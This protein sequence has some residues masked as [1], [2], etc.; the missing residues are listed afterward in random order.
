MTETELHV[1]SLSV[2][3]T[4]SHG[5][6]VALTDV[7]FKVSPGEVVGL[8]GE[9]GAGK[10][11]IARAIA[12]QLPNNADISGSIFMDGIDLLASRT[13]HTDL[14]NKVNAALCF[15]NPRLA[16]SP[17]RTIG[18]QIADRLGKHQN[19]SNR[20]MSDD[21][22]ELLRRVGIRDP[23]RM[24]KSFP[25]EL[26]GGMCQRAMIA[27]ALAC[28]S[29]VLLADEPTTGLDVTL[30]R[31]ILDLF[32][33]MADRDHRQVLVISHD[34][35]AIASICDRLLVLYAG[36]LVEAGSTL[37]IVQNPMHPY[38]RSLIDAVPQLDREITHS[39]PLAG[40]MPQ[41]V[42]IPESCPFL[43]RCKF[44][45]HECEAEIPPTVIRDQKREVRCFH[46]SEFTR[47]K[48]YN[49]DHN[50]AYQFTQKP[51]DSTTKRKDYSDPIIRLENIRVG[52]Q[53]RT[54]SF[55]QT[56]L[57]DI[58]LTFNRGEVVGIVGESGC[59]KSTL[60]RTIMGLISPLE[61]EVW[62]R[63][64][65]LK[66]KNRAELRRL[67][68]HMQLVFQDALDSLNPRLPVDEIITDPLRLKKVSRDDKRISVENIMNKVSLDQG[69]KK[70]FPRELS[71]GQAQRVGIARGLV[72]DPELIIF[73]EPTSALDATIQAQVLL[74]IRSLI[75]RKDRTY[76]FIT[77][78][79]ATV[80]GLCDRVIVMYLG[81]VVEDGP[82]NR[83]FKDP[84]H[85]YTQALLAA[86]PRLLGR[87]VDDA[88]KLKRDF[89][90]NLEGVGC[91]LLPRCPIS[92]SLC[93]QNP[94]L[95][96][97]SEG[98]KVACWQATT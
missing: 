55:S 34:I 50:H 41:L 39:L 27:L 22:Y 3:L 89:E 79:L 60:A 14:N 86:I 71:G 7:S 45:D 30:T 94:E 11:M 59:G 72:V 33:E 29:S 87:T 81:R 54:H 28:Q 93:S 37:D 68:R 40:V 21:V 53:S 43:P 95:L 38:T 25:H 20:K 26:S 16:L 44:S 32:R 78:D 31:E 96:E 17:T 36:V 61:G 90:E 82:V 19:L 97:V 67:R 23:E 83:V 4:G 15:Q 46:P 2:S 64:S 47:K 10:S 18:K 70:R 1:N 80:L 85:P 51:V 75:E 63:G 35:A 92:T 74:L 13:E 98:H 65:N 66:N 8:V 76:I 56:V 84:T 12:N 48:N 91:S 52:Y 24:Y 57:R 42:A 62:F 69:F 58:N 9:S 77:H 49:C 73:D 6:V 5:K 88:V